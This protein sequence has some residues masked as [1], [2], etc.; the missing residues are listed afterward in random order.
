VRRSL[1]SF[2]ALAALL[3]GCAKA[4]SPA[5]PPASVQSPLGPPPP[6]GPVIGEK[7]VVVVPDGPPPKDLKIEDL[8]EGSGRGAEPG[9]TLV[10]HY[11]GVAYST[12]EEFDAS[13]NTGTPF[14]VSLGTGG[15]I[16]GWEQGLVGMKEGGRRR[17]TIPPRLAYGE[18]GHPGAGIGPNETLIFVIDL[19]QLT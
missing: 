19:L 17:L 14:P 1:A 15:V 18:D 5:P 6:T 4:A 8:S 12:G 16:P 9:D 3:T 7:P 11:V 10:V 2:V 13:W